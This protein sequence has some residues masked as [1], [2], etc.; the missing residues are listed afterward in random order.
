M[1]AALSILAVLLLSSMLLAQAGPAAPQSPPA[2]QAQP[3][4]SSSTDTKS[5]PTTKSIDTKTLQDTLSALQEQINRQQQE[6]EALKEKLAEQGTPHITEASLHVAP[7]A[8]AAAPAPQGEAK[9]PAAIELA[10]GK[11]KIGA[12]A[13]ADWAAYPETGF[14]PAFLDT[15][16]MYPGPNND[17]YNAF[18]VNRVYVNIFYSPTDWL[19]FRV[20]PDVYRDIGSPAAVKLS[21]DSGI[22]STPNGSLSF[23][24]KYAYAEFTKFFGDGAFKDDNL[25]FGQQT[26]PLIDWEEGLYDY[27]FV[28]LVPWN[29]ISLSS[30]YTGVSLNGPIKWNGKQYL[31]YQI[32]VFNNSNFH[33]F[34]QAETKTAMGR[35]S[36]YPL[37][38]TSKYQGLGF[39]FFGDYGY[40][41]VAPDTDAAAPVIRLAALVHYESPHRGAQIAFEYDWGR[42]AFSTGNLFSGS[43]PLDLLGLGVTPY[44]GMTAI[45]KTILSGVKTKQQGFDVFGHINI[46]NTKF[47]FFGLYQHFQPNTDVPNDPL[48]FHRVVAGVSYRVSK[49]LRLALDNQDVI[50]PRSGG[51]AAGVPPS[52]KA[53]F[54]NMEFTF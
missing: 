34:E 24:L 45:D 28:S 6:I 13:Y 1:K 51:P 47:A 32:G 42:N 10:N 23:R 11:I 3:G 29:F 30:T 53:L 54:A 2:P 12:V 20:T 19:T 9:K 18:S 40:S 43:A 44:A 5:I 17:G 15:P 37:G 46:P 7:A 36:I 49:N 31:D 8:A 33:G 35:L 4:E 22:G 39:T 16:H 41:N 38:A 27:R 14:G 50:Y 21:N 48:D 26:N 52:V 25:R